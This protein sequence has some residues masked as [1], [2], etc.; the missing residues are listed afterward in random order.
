[1]RCSKQVFKIL[2]KLRVVLFSKLQVLAK[3]QFLIKNR[4]HVSH[5][6]SFRLLCVTLHRQI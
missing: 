1:M 6:L 5:P 3:E 4:T 2:P